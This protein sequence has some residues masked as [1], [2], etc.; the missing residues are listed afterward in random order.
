MFFK[1]RKNK[2]KYQRTNN[3]IVCL[4][5]FLFDEFVSKKN[6]PG[7]SVGTSMKKWAYLI[8]V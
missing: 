3:N 2:Y 7:I 1:T 4:I 5:V 6:L 8:K